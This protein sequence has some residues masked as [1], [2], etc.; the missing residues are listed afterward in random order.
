[1]IARAAIVA[2][3]RTWMGTH[4]RH[5]ARAKGVGV[6]CIGMIGMTAL[7]CGVSGAQEWR[8]DRAMHSYGRQPDPIFLANACA[9]FLDPVQ[10]SA[11]GLGDVLVLAFRRQPQHFALISRDAPKYVIHAY[12][13]RRQVVENGLPIAGAT[14]LRAYR[15]RGVE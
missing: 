7:A 3:A 13:Q 14:V 9:R 12:L 8:E 6:D 4:Y 11:A 2:E 5:Q 15:L 10:V 1:M